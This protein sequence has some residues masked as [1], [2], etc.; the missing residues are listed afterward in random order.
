MDKSGFLKFKPTSSRMRNSLTKFNCMSDITAY[1][2]ERTKVSSIKIVLVRLS[3]MVKT[4]YRINL[5]L[6]VHICH[7]Y[8]LELNI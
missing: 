5:L 2:R 8:W 1:W 7:P 4:H 3:L 6:I